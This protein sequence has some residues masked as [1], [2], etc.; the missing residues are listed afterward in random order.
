[1]KKLFLFAVLL[2][3]AFSAFAQKPKSKDD[4][5]KDIAA[6]LLTKKP[7]DMAKAYPLSKD[8]L[9]RFGKDEKDEKIKGIR[10]FVSRYRVHEFMVALDGNKYAVAFPA[11]K[12]IL[13]DQPENVEVLLNLAYAGYTALST[14][15]KS[16][17]DDSLG[18]ARKTIQLLDAGSLPR[19]FVPFKDKEEATAFMYFVVGNLVLE[20]DKKDAVVNIYK[21]TLYESQIK[22]NSAAYYLIAVCYEDL[23]SKMATD[24]KA[25]SDSKKMSDADFNAESAK[26]A[27]V[28]DLMM[29]AYARAVKKAETDKNPDAPQWKQRLTTVYKFI[30]KSEDGLHAYIDQ[31]NTTPMPDPSK[32]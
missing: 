27:K 31:V 16:Y 4:S 22:N 12:E 19:S 15:D 20:K 18:Y 9:A 28:V 25:K 7:E 13:A 5:Y 2:T 24:L 17:A 21:A 26:V 30:K 32:T 10:T 14:G 1:M 29:D 8:F 3:L 6:L 23:Y 11:G